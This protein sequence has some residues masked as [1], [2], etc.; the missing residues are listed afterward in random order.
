M[1]VQL[2]QICLVS[3][4][5]NK[6]VAELTEV[7]GVNSAHVD[8]GIIHFGLENNLMAFGHNFMEVV[9]PVQEQTAA[10]RYLD[11]RQGDGGYMVI[12]QTETQANQEAAKQRAADN[13]IRIAWQ[14]ENDAISI[15]QFHRG[16]MVAAFFELDWDKGEDFNGHWDPVGGDGWQDKVKT[17]VTEGF[18]GVE[19]QGPDPALMA[20]RWSQLADIPLDTNDGISMQLN[21]AFIRFVELGDDR[22]PGLSAIHLAVHQ[23]ST[24]LAAAKERGCY[25]SDDQVDICGVHFYLHDAGES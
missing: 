18:L 3:S 25:V 1:S 7:F 2:R 4:D 10:G 22:G 5:I 21:N 17:D 23:R 16:D 8:A 9:A 24:V 6:V 12:C 19:L 15:C 14:S 13:N 20:E 11:R